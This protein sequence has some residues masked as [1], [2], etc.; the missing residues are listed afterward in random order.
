ME[1]TKKLLFNKLKFEHSYLLK[2]SPLISR[3][4]NHK[5]VEFQ[6]INLKNLH[7]NTDIF[8]QIIANKLKNRNNKLLNVLRSALSL[9]RLPRVNRVKERLGR[10]NR[11]RL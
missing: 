9:V 11:A 2:I 7:L 6:V 5:K 3:L 4:Y 10:D 8:T 1:T